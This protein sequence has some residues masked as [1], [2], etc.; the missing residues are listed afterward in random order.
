MQGNNLDAQEILARRNAT[1]QVEVSPAVV[2]EHI[3]NTPF[4]AT[5]IEAI[6]PD[7]EPLLAAR[8]SRRRVVDFG[9]IGNNRSFVGLGD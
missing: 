8:A 4:P 1:G 5:G 7:L 9:Q 6:L 2:L 3:I